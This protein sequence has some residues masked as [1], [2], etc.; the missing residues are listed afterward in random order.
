MSPVTIVNPRMQPCLGVS[1]VVIKYHDKTNSGRRGF[2]LAYNSQVM[3][4]HLG[5][6]GA[7]GKNLGHDRS[8]GRMLLTGL[9]TPPPPGFLIVLF[10]ITQD[11]LPRVGSTHRGL[12][13]PTPITN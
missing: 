7:Q 9:L 3:C 13:S 11:G 1:I 10:Y 4:R 12:G 2:L 8:H 6:S 5:A